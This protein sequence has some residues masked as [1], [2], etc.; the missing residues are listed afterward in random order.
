MIA[1][2]KSEIA[3]LQD[4]ISTIF[5]E[6]ETDDKDA[7]FLHA[8]CVHEGDANGGH[9]FN[10]IKDHRNKKWWKFNDSRVGEESEEEVFRSANGGYAFRAAYWV[11]YINKDEKVKA[12]QLSIYENQDNNSYRPLIPRHVV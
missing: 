10:Y 12:E 5:K 11:V 1:K 7:Y 6:I 9:Y 8:I 2:L 3:D 4:Q